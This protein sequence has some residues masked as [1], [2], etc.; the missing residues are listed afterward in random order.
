[1]PD[2]DFIQVKQM[3]GEL[4]V[5]QKRQQLGCTLTT[6]ELIF[7]KPHASYQIF[8]SDI[9]GIIPFQLKKPAPAPEVLGESG[10]SPHFS[11]QYHRISALRMFVINRSGGFEKGVTDILVPLNE[12]FIQHIQRC[13]DFIPIPTQ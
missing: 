10:V 9:L 12:R 4:L 2:S 1:M 11:T 5:S 8:L 3:H 7:Q 13:T 6:K